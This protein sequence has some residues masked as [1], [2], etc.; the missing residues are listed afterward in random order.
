ME[1]TVLRICCVITNKI[2]SKLDGSEAGQP[3]IRRI[4]EAGFLN[5]DWEWVSNNKAG[6]ERVLRDNG[7]FA[8]IMEKKSSEYSAKNNCQLIHIGGLLNEKS[9]AIAMPK[10]SPYQSKINDA[11]MTLQNGKLL[12]LKN[13]WWRDDACREQSIEIPQSLAQQLRTLLMKIMESPRP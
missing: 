3:T 1:S 8:F 5:D 12:A 9:Y 4:W 13:K 7:K 2:T 10:N 6:M 11:L